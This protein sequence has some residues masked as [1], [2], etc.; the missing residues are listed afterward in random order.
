LGGGDTCHNVGDLGSDEVGGV[1]VFV[2]IQPAEGAG[3]V[4]LGPHGLVAGV[5]AAT[6]ALARTD[7]V[8]F[9][10]QREA[11]EGEFIA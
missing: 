10:G 8:H 3:D 11:S 6:V 1:L 2:H 7:A 5:F 9:K 4:A